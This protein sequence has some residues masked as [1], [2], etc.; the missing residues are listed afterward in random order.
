MDFDHH[1]PYHPYIAAITIVVLVV[2]LVFFILCIFLLLH[3]DY[4]Q[5]PV[6]KLTANSMIGHFIFS[7]FMHSKSVHLNLLYKPLGKVWCWINHHVF[8]GYLLITPYTLL[9]FTVERL[10]YI[11][12]PTTHGQKFGKVAIS[13]MLVLPWIITVLVGF[14]VNIPFD[15]EIVTEYEGDKHWNENETAYT[16]YVR[17]SGNRNGIDYQMFIFG[18]IGAILPLIACFIISVVVLCMWCCYKK[19]HSRGT[20]YAL[21]GDQVEKAVPDSVI[22]VALLN[23]LYVVIM[24]FEKAVYISGPMERLGF[25]LYGIIEGIVLMGTLGNVRDKIGTY[26]R[27]CCRK[28]R[29]SKTVR[30]DTKDKNNVE[31]E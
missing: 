19:E 23:F 2:V 22:A 16:C 29:E 25:T 6:Q 18:I 26:F 15:I 5:F 31:L 11:R 1:A 17:G 13:V 14:I 24:F 10:V 21:M 3:R 9:M 27:W 20:N 12:N 30:Y 8:L 4:W 28:R 7:L